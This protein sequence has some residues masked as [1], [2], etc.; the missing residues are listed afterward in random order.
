[1]PGAEF[2]NAFSG[3]LGENILGPK[4]EYHTKIK[5][6]KE[7]DMS[8]DG[9]MSALAKDVGGIIAYVEL[10]VE[11]GGKANRAGKPLGD[12]FFLKTAAKC[13]D[14]DTKEDVDRYHYVNN[15][16]DGKINLPGFKLNTGLKGLIPGVIGDITKINPAGLLSGFVEGSKPW[17]KKVRKKVIDNNNNESYETHHIALSDL[18]AHE[19]N[20]SDRKK[21]RNFK[22]NMKNNDKHAQCKESFQNLM[23]KDQVPNLYITSASL[24]MIYLLYNLYHK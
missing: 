18:K 12:R 3:N 22:K 10:L 2:L 21:L 24:F 6:P 1:M 8:P 4:Y 19:L 11:G 14:V 23:N 16:I 13:K 9:N 5:S 15:Q 20:A 17:C 7:L